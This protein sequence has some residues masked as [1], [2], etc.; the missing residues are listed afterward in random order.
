MSRTGAAFW[1]AVEAPRAEDEPGVQPLLTAWLRRHRLLNGFSAWRST[2]PDAHHPVIGIRAVREFLL[3][4]ERQRAD[5]ELAEAMDARW[6]AFHQLLF[7]LQVVGIMACSLV[8]TA[9]LVTTFFRW[10]RSLHD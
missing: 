10:V 9:F 3:Q 4:L 1:I 8:S 6:E 7:I 5:E 2:Q